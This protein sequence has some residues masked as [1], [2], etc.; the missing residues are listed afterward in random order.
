MYPRY[1]HCLIIIKEQDGYI[2]SLNAGL[3]LLLSDWTIDIIFT[4]ASP[5]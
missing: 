3:I 2:A 1:L 4:S 5:D